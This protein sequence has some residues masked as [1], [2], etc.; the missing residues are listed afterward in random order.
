MLDCVRKRSNERSFY[1]DDSFFYFFLVTHGD[2][3]W[4]PLTILSR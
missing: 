3:N 2:L 4:T 1:V